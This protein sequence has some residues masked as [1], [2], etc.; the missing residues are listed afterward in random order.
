MRKTALI[1][2]RTRGCKKR[3][4]R[5]LVSPLQGGHCVLLSVLAVIMLAAG[6]CGREA[7]PPVF[8][9]ATV[10]AAKAE[11]K[12]MPLAINAIGTV[13]AYKSINVYS[14]VTGQLLKTH[15]REGEDVRAGQLLFTIDPAPYRE[16]LHQAEAKLA[17]SVAQL[18]FNEEEA[19]RYAFLLEK[20][21]VSKSEAD[22]Y[23][24]EAAAYRAT[25]KADRA[26]VEDARLNL[27]Y[28]SIRAPFA[29]RT[30]GYTVN[31]G[32]VVRANE[33][34]LTTLNQIS[35]VYVRFSVPEKH[36]A[37]IC[38]RHRDGTIA[39]RVTPGKTFSPAD[40][41]GK[42]VFI[43]NAIDAASGMISLKGEFPNS[44][45]FLWPG[46]FVNVS[47][48]LAVIPGAVV[49]PLRAVQTGDNGQFVFVVKGD[50]TAE[51]RPVTVERVEGEEA[52]IAKGL[53]GGE[54]LITDGHLKVR[55]GGKVEIRDSLEA[56]ANNDKG[57]PKAGG[58]G[59]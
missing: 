2:D 44:D 30:G 5:G 6:G 33:T 19:K 14:R 21:A 18:Q 55:P 53:V 28:C 20:G 34:S 3:D 58:G 50:M 11:K 43:D 57:K 12:D 27:D 48:R 4:D 26:E 56:T 15:F 38:R 59:Q 9:P 22:R 13:E 54:T 40:P 1:W 32:T 8:P 16:K 41:V 23:L 7:P 42:L 52:V 17:R 10:L 35:P 25:V 29:G 24:T 46:Q 47:L 39:V 49:A 36:L 45:R 31:L 51:L 37:E